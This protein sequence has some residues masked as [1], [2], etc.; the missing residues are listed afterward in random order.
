MQENKQEKSK[1]KQNI[2]LYLSQK[3]ISDYEFYKKSGVTR[4]I[5]TQNN[6][7]RE[8]NLARFL[9]YAP[10][11]NLEWLLKGEGDMLKTKRTPDVTPPKTERISNIKGTNNTSHHQD[12]S[13]YISQLLDTIRSQAEEAGRLKARIDELERHGGENAGDVRSSGSANAG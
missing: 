10:D 12:I 3:G 9:D 11:V 1:I 13:A 7:I 5:L 6:G 8:D 2:L 4:G